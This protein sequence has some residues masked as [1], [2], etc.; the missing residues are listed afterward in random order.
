MSEEPTAGDAVDGLLG[1][2]WVQTIAAVVA[3]AAAVLG[4]LQ[5]TNTAAF[6]PMIAVPLMWRLGMS[7]GRRQ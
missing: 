3:T 6:I 5:P 1:N 2:R 7:Y 4:A